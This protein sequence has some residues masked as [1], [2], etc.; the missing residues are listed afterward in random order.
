MTASMANSQS[1]K[2]TSSVILFREE[3]AVD[4][5]GV[6]E[7]GKEPPKVKEARRGD[8][9]GM[10]PEGPDSRVCG[11]DVSMALRQSADEASSTLVT[12]TSG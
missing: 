2:S 9:T 12:S 10:I 4:A 5:E 1:S 3:E 7:Y 6:S 8:G 11:E